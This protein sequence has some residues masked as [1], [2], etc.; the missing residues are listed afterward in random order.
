MIWYTFYFFISVMQWWCSIWTSE[1]FVD[2]I[3]IVCFIYDAFSFVLSGWTRSRWDK[4]SSITFME[5]RRKFSPRLMHFWTCSRKTQSLSYYDY[6][7]L[8]WTI[9][10]YLVTLYLCYF[11]LFCII[12]VLLALQGSLKTFYLVSKLIY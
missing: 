2:W 10:I 9:F 11:C 3:T 6:Q 5:N 8:C 1:C 4:R 12:Q 7:Y